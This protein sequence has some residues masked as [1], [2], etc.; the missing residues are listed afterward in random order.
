MR[1]MSRIRNNVLQRSLV[2]HGENRCLDD[3]VANGKSI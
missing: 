1:D 3:D 2:L